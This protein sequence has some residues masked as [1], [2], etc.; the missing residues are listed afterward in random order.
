VNIE[1][2]TDDSLKSLHTLIRE[3]VAYDDAN[4]HAKKYGV[5]EI[6]DWKSQ[7]DAFERELKKRQINFSAIPW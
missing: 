1:E 2:L 4:Q 6:S 5:R 7:A 3:A